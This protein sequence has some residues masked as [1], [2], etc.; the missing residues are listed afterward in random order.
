MREPWHPGETPEEQ[1]ARREAYDRLAGAAR[2]VGMSMERL[3][4]LLR[5]LLDNEVET[6]R[7]LAEEVY[8]VPDHSLD[9]LLRIRLGELG[10]EERGGA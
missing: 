5:G 7:F 9:D 6:R 1:A 2:R 3:G 8:G 10:E 4:E